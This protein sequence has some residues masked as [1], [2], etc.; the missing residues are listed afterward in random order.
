[1]GVPGCAALYPESLW[2]LCHRAAIARALANDPSVILA[3]EPCASLDANTAREVLA[4]F[5]TVCRE[6]YKTL[7]I[8]SHDA[9]VLGAVDQV[10]D[11][12]EINRV[13]YGH[14]AT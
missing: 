9:I 11:M 10:F 6:E 1:M 12:A 14:D 5:L 2:G 3:D 4:A 8:V 13:G 7:F